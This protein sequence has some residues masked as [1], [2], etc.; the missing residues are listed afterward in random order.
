M[1]KVVSLHWGAQSSHDPDGGK[2]LA[3]LH[4]VIPALP[5][6]SGPRFHVIGHSIANRGLGRRP[7][8]NTGPCRTDDLRNSWPTQTNG[9]TVSRHVQCKLST[10]HK[11]RPK[12]RIEVP[13]S[14]RRQRRPTLGAVSTT[15]SVFKRTSPNW[16]TD[17][18]SSSPRF[19]AQH[20]A[21]GFATNVGR[22]KGLAQRRRVARRTVHRWW[23]M[24]LLG[25]LYSWPPCPPQAPR[26]HRQC[27]RSPR[28][29]GRVGTRQR[30]YDGAAASMARLSHA[31][32]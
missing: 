19:H 31:L 8:G 9:R 18:G 25:A 21:L 4:G 22:H 3:K 1:A 15:T 24:W 29:H 32:V 17:S 6:L 14:C 27:A 20:V 26:I 11:T 10:G 2:R 7:R 30:G 5:R 13:S 12:H 28:A 23:L 16:Y